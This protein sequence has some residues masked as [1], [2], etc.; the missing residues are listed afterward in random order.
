MDLFVLGT[1]HSVAPGAMRER[2][3]VDPER[4][5]VTLLR[6]VDSG[7][8]EE[9]G[10]LVTCGR[11]EIYGVAEHPTRA[12]RLLARLMARETGVARG[13]LEA[14]VYLRVGGA[15]ATHLFRVASGLDSVVQGEAQILGQVR[16][17]VSS[18]Q[19]T[20]TMGPTLKRLFQSAVACG[21]RVRTET[22]IGRGAASLA[23]ASLDLVRR[24]AG[25]LEGR[26]AVVVGA[27][28]TGGLVARLLM[29]A[30]VARLQVVNR[31]PE[32]ARQLASALGGTAHTLDEL[33]AL[34]A[35]ADLVVGATASPTHL[36]TPATLSGVPL[37]G[38]TLYFI[39]LGHPRNVDPALSAR[40]GV[41]IL[42][43]E[44]VERRTRAAREARAA[45]VPRAEALVDDEVARFL[46]W[47]N[48]RHALPVV[49]AVRERVLSMAA[50]EAER[51]GQGLTPEQQEALRRFAR[52]LART[53]LHEPTAALR[54]A[55]PHTDEGRSLL[56]SAGSLFGVEGST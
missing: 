21:K 4:V 56:D 44:D 3:H 30:G 8:L 45:Q 15:A 22:D 36:I 5:Q 35:G 51:H 47:T 12:R 39:D 29:K 48:G 50:R 33:P 42:D 19:L 9:A 6:L 34:L 31:T 40:A 41:E 7:L 28:E 27:G 10:A 11:Y 2:L 14:H 20:T 54:E 32:P 25:G 16:E 24:R 38:R 1:S 17:V 49:R 55:D 53:L 13:E 37:A 23:G 26:S 52:A 46:A 18:P 43:L